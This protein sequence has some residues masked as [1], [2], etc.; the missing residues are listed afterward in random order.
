MTKESYSRLYTDYRAENLYD[1]FSSPFG[2][3]FRQLNEGQ[4]AIFLDFYKDNLLKVSVDDKYQD[5]L[6]ASKY[7]SS[8]VLRKLTSD[9]RFLTNDYISKSPTVDSIVF[10]RLT[11]EYSGELQEKLLMDFVIQLY[12]RMAPGYAFS[13]ISKVDKMIQN[14]KFR[15][16]L[17]DYK[18]SEKG[19]P[20]YD[21]TLPDARGNMIQLAD[22]KGKLLVVDF[23]FKS[24]TQCVKLEK[25]MK[26]IREIFKDRKNIAFLSVNVDAKKSNWL[27]GM[28]SGLYTGKESINVSTY[29]LGAQH[30]FF[31][32]YGYSGCPQMLIIGKDQ[33]VVMANPEKPMFENDR[34]SFI[35]LLNRLAH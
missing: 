17:S 20:A 28:R 32:Y 22:F 16:I 24:C 3:G 10:N 34:D 12:S 5:Q 6:V 25:Q 13:Y 27:E 30:P 19:K 21:F 33:R 26:I 2:L 11:H 4:K 1:Y 18:V 31:K 9:I 35:D 15:Q 7:Y 29:G 8:A 23:W 14:P